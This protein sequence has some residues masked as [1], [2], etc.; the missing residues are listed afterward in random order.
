M[1][2]AKRERRDD[3]A[4]WCALCGRSP[5]PVV[6]LPDG[7]VAHPGCADDPVFAEVVETH[8]VADEGGTMTHDETLPVGAVLAALAVCDIPTPTAMEI[9]RV[10][11]HA[12]DAELRSDTA[13]LLAAF[14]AGFATDRV[15]SDEDRDA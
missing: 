13:T 15:A 1:N 10:A 4:P 3:D 5:M 12:R 6:E 11:R 8:R 14:E 2:D 7:C 9:L